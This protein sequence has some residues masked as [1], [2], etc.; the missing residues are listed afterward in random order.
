MVGEGGREG[1]QTFIPSHSHSHNCRNTTSTTKRADEVSI[2][3]GHRKLKWGPVFSVRTDGDGF[4]RAPQQ[5]EERREI[6][7]CR[8][9]VELQQQ[10]SNG[11]A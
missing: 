11:T 10:E 1:S 3:K 8:A 2:L 9:G 5:Q 7:E 6:L 4:G